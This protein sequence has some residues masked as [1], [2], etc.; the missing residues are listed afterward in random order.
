LEQV[1]L[2]ARR[3]G[4]SPAAVLAREELRRVLADP[5]HTPQEKTAAV[6]RHLFAQV[7]PRLSAAR[8]AFESALGRLGWQRHPRLRLQPPAAF[9]GPD[10]Y[11][12][13]K[14]R[15]APELRQLLAEIDR[16]TRQE[17]FEELTR[18]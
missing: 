5:H 8:E 12:A 2:L 4:L 10:Y 1:A 14:F 15:D 7:Y 3:E 9:E 11:L 18:R 13:I 17:E 16:L 6:R